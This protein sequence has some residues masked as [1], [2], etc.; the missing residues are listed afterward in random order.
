MKGVQP[1]MVFLMETKQNEAHYERIRREVGLDNATYVH[2]TGING[3]LALWWSNEVS[4]QIQRMDKK[5]IDS[6]VSSRLFGR[7]FR[8]TWVYGDPDYTRRIQNWEELKTMGAN[9]RDPW[10]CVGDF[11]DIF[12]YREKV[13]G[14]RKGAIRLM[15]ST[16]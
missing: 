5:F 7:D 3:G 1:K 9:L 6:T 4:V 16:T 15:D 11:N 2:R 8:V 10:I 13:G 12:H 14:R